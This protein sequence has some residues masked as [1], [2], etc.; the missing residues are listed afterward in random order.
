MGCESVVA[1]V[2]GN[3]SD[4][5]TSLIASCA[6]SSSSDVWIEKSGVLVAIEMGSD[7]LNENVGF[8]SRFSWG[9]G[10]W[11]EASGVLRRTLG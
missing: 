6:C 2:L 9:V 11:R 4:S 5:W 10:S 8:A 7:V 1:D 3:E